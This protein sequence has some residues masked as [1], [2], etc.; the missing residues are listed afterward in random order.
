[1]SDGVVNGRKRKKWKRSGSSYS[2]SVELESSTYE[3]DFRF[4][5]G[6]ELSYDP[7]YDTDY[8]SVASENQ[9]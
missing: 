2:D 3:S 7:D 1:M 8:D 5:L 6:R 4:S 9:P